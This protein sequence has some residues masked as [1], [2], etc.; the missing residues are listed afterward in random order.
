MDLDK[1][2]KVP[3]EV[4]YEHHAWTEGQIEAE[5]KRKD[6]FSD[7]Y[8]HIAKTVIIV[9]LGAVASVLILGLETKFENKVIEVSK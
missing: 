8:K 9:V 4:H 5:R 3:F 6:W 2:K 1:D 7:I